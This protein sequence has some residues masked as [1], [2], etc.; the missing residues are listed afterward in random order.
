VRGDKGRGQAPN[1][2]SVIVS[3]AIPNWDSVMNV[4]EQWYRQPRL[5]YTRR[6]RQRCVLYEN[7]RTENTG[8]TSPLSENVVCI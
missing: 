7:A 6:G 4:D 5:F 1:I 8:P 3:V 2:L